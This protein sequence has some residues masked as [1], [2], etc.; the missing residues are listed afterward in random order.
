MAGEPI[1]GRHWT[2]EHKARIRTSRIEA[3][4]RIVG[5][6]SHMTAPPRSSTDPRSATTA[7]AAPRS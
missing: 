6:L 3:T 1:A 2:A 4:R 7:I 5:A